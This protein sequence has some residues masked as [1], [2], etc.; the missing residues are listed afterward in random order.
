MKRRSEVAPVRISEIFSSLQG[1]GPRMGERHLFI[2]FEA[3]HL[4]CSYCD[5][6]LKRGMRMSI[7]QVLRKIDQLEKTK[8]P[9]AFI[10]LTGGEPLLSVEFLKQLCLPLKAR[11]YKIL[12]ETNGVLW[13]ELRKVIG[14]CDLISMDWKLPSV[15]HTK[16]FLEEHLRFLRIAKSRKL[17]VKIP[18]SLGMNQGEYESHLRKVAAVAPRTPVFLQP[19]TFRKQKGCPSRKLWDLLIE[20][21]RTGSRIHSEVRIGIQLHKIFNIP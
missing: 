17:Y 7:A 2:R 19:V 11:R 20:L 14:L 16:D 6:R 13:Q 18:V 3:C 10:S 21:Q 9:H 8:G 4:K 1:E 5:E 12:L 15:G